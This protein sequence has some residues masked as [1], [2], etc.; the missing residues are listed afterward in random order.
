MSAP[1]GL[2]DEE[3]LARQCARELVDCTMDRE[4][5]IRA[6]NQAQHALDKAIAALAAARKPA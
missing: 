5:A 6:F 2:S 1:D 3:R 4:R